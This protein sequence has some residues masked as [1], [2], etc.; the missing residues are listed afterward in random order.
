M[1]K[2]KVFNAEE[3]APE[4][5]MHISNDDDCPGVEEPLEAVVVFPDSTLDELKFYSG[6]SGVK[7]EKAM[8]WLIRG[9]LVYEEK[10]NH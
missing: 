5:S 10:I 7:F 1:R 3:I 6:L 4:L 2:N 9:G 8:E